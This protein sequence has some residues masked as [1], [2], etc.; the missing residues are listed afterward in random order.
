MQ[1]P[2]QEDLN[3]TIEPICQ[4]RINSPKWFRSVQVEGL[5]VELLPMIGSQSNFDD[6][7]QEP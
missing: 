2:S 5:S 1:E 6:L 4:I 7:R 3:L